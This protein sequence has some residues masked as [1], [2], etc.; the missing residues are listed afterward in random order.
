MV[1][2]SAQG[3]ATAAARDVLVWGPECGFDVRYFPESP[4]EDAAAL[5]KSLDSWKPDIVHAHCWYQQYDYG[6][7]VELSLRYPTVATIHDVFAVNQYGVECW[8]CYRNAFCLGCPALGPFRRF[9]P[10]YRILDRVRKR[11]LNRRYRGA[12]IYPSEWMKTRFLRSEW[13]RR[14][15]SVIPYGIDVEGFSRGLSKRRQLLISDDAPVILF[16]GHMYSKDDHRKGLPDLL[17]AMDLMRA[18]LPDVRL[19]VAGKVHGSFDRPGVMFLAD[20]PRSELRDLYATA[21]VFCLPSR[22][23]NLP[24]AILEAMAASL[25]VVATRVG[26]IPEEVQDGE[27]G[28]ITPPKD[29]SALAQ[30]LLR[31]LRKD[32]Q[33]LRQRLGHAG[34]LR[35]GS[36]FSRAHS[37]QLHKALYHSLLSRPEASSV[38]AR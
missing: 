19:L 17:A 31:L 4:A 3:G 33:P 23:D 35:V 27:T 16:A 13:G 18:E 9:R 12:L 2:Q 10:N 37:A 36:F 28:L 25:P 32:A 20:L 5:R 15:A 1:N 30:A 22:G 21:D 6:T 7:L 14:P 11:A 26:G 24:V 38:P 34:H 29:P 8:E